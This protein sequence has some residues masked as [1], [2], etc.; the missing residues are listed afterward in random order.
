MAQRNRQGVDVR[1]K[2]TLIAC[3]QWGGDGLAGAGEQPDLTHKADDLGLEQQILDDHL[4]G[5]VAHGIGRQGG[6]IN[7]TRLLACDE[8]V[9]VLVWFATRRRGAAFGLGGMVGSRWWEIGQDVG[10]ARA[11]LQASIFITQGLVFATEGLILSGELLKQ[12]EQ[13]HH[14]L[15]DGRVDDRIKLEIRDLHRVLYG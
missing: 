14:R 15:A 10:L 5:A 3:W 11:T 7:D 4:A 9:A 6:R 2:G 13:L 8:Q 12:I 1:A